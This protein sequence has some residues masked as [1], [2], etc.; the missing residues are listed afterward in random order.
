MP[1]IN[2]SHIG[3]TEHRFDIEPIRRELDAH[4]EL[5]NEYKGRLNH[6]RSPH[7]HTDD[8]WLRFA[9]DNLHDKERKVEGPHESV[10]YPA[11]EQLP[12]TK[13]LALEMFELIEG[14]ELGGIL[15]IRVPPGKEIYPHVDAGWHAQHHEKFAVQIS[16]H[17][18]QEFAFED[19]SLSALPGESYWLDNSYPHWV[20]NP[21]PKDWINMTV[22]YRK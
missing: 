20:L 15:I 11:S 18:R 14:K 19:G 17:P 5:W 13:A 3:L 9:K 21:T 12:A 2:S 4:P 16:G 22:C 1:N 7:R 10:W 8:I 6:P